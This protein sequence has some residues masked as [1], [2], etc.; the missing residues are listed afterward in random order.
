MTPK[1]SPY[2]PYILKRIMDDTEYKTNFVID[3]TTCQ[4]AGAVASTT[5]PLKEPAIP[6]I[7]PNEAK[8]K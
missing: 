1:H 5:T 6:I 2:K 4:Y 3:I 8:N 7:I